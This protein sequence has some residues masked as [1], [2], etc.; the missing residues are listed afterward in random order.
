MIVNMVNNQS[1]EDIPNDFG[2]ASLGS[3]SHN[4]GYQSTLASD[5]VLVFGGTLGALKIMNKY[6][7]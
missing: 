1:D 4:L 2:N 6:L 5:Y 7:N 3:Y